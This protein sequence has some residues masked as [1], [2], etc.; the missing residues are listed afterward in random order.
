MR[1]RSGEDVRREEEP[2]QKEGGGNRPVESPGLKKRMLKEKE[3]GRGREE[4]EEREERGKRGKRGKRE[5]R[6]KQKERERQQSGGRT[7]N[8]EELYRE[9][10]GI[11]MF[12]SGEDAN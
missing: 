2:G 12:K 10:I 7:D 5:R 3:R 9:V 8:A 6:G 4:R 1:A 11:A